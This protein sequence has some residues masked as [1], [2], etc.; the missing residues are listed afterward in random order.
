MAGHS[1]AGGREA[2]PSDAG[3]DARSPRWWKRPAFLVVLVVVA[4]VALL[5]GSY[6]SARGSRLF[7]GSS[8]TAP[9]AAQ[10]KSGN[11]NAVAASGEKLLTI[12]TPPSNTRVQ[13]KLSKDLGKPVFA[14]EFR[15]YGLGPGGTVVIQVTKATSQGGTTLAPSFAKALVGQNLQAAIALDSVA[16]LKTG[17]SY[18]GDL[19]MVEQSGVD[20]FLIS[21]VV[22]AK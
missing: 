1:S 21:H 3:P 12:V 4:V 15:P 18:S 22:R 9:V 17:G 13:L 8:A 14:L 16:V 10:A 5:G 11:P 20:S 7:K 19:T 2:R 6:L